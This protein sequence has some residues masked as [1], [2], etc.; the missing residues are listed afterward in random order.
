MQIHEASDAAT[1]VAIFKKEKQAGLDKGMTEDEATNFAVMK[2]RESINFMI[3]GNSKSLNALRQ[4]IPFLSA[5]ITS[6]DTVYRAATGY[7]LPPAEKAAAKKL[8]KQ[9]AA[10][11]LGSSIAYAM[12]MQDDD[13]YKKL[14]D[15]I[16]D[17]N[18]LIKNPL[19]EGFIKVAV[20]YEV[21]FL[22]K[23]LP[24]VAI[25][26]LAGN[27]TG[28]EMLKSY[29]DGFLHNL[30]T[31][32][33]PVPQAVKP[34]LEVITN[35]SFFTG[36][37]IESIG[38]GRLPV[39]MRGRNASETAKFLSQAGLGAVGLS[40]AKIDALVQGYMAEAG[41][42]SFSL[43]DHLITTVQG[44]E[45]TSKNLAKQPFFKAFLTDPNSNKAVADFYQIEQ[46]ANQ[47]AQEFS[48]MTKTGLGKD[49]VELMQDE[50]KRKLMA[51]APALRRVA[52]SMTAIRK[53]IEAT[54]NNQSIPPD[55][56]R[57]MVNKLTAQYNRVAEQGVKLANTLGVR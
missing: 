51:S 44:K 41:T 46:T 22:F 56:R 38:E 17:N 37:P 19:G 3:H 31:G 43:A 16:K 28:K 42:F 13:E 20:P 40:P 53:A 50:D 52:T 49:A 21:G 25:R 18:W 34:A 12:L 6:L 35:Y 47:V 4:M 29:K 55:E 32:G 36:N 27:S 26:G 2:A 45:P 33:V 48:T 11:M 39:E 9:R 14:P 57:E 30:P 5:S 23:T 7:N 54:N 10:L 24:E 8:F 15:Y 1:R